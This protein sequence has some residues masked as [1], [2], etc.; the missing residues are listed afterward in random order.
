MSHIEIQAG[1][2]EKMWFNEFWST[3]QSRRKIRKTAYDAIHK[4]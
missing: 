1:L 2:P 3:A 4:D